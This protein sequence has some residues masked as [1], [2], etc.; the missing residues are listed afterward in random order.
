MV[1]PIV[2]SFSPTGNVEYTRN[3]AFQPFD[4][5]GDMQRVTDIQKRPDAP[6]YFI[7]WMLGPNAGRDHTYG[8]STAYGVLSTCPAVEQVMLFNSYEEAVAHEVTVLNAMRK[9]GVSFHVEKVE[10]MVKSRKN[11]PLTDV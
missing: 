3:T 11:K 5:R 2:L 8:M 1:Q 7:H 10:P 4:G 6:L 9:A